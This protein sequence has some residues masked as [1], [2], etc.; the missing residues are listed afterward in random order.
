MSSVRRSAC[1]TRRGPRSCSVAASRRS[2][3]TPEARGLLTPFPA[4]LDARPLGGFV[5]QAEGG[6][7]QA[8]GIR[9]AMAAAGPVLAWPTPGFALAGVASVMGAMNTLFVDDGRARLAITYATGTLVSLGLAIAAKATKQDAASWKRP[10]MMW[11]ALTLGAGL[12]A[13]AVS[14]LGPGSLLIAALVLIRLF[15]NEGVVA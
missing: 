3:P 15:T 2:T 5:G 8:V 12:G 10:L 1:A 4:P 9:V 6:A 13:M 14:L 11:V 7:G